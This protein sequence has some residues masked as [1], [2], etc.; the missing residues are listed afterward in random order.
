[1][2]KIGNL[3]VAAAAVS[4]AIVS[5]TVVNAAQ[6]QSAESP[7]DP[8]RIEVGW[9]KGTKWATGK[10]PKKPKDQS[11]STTTS[12]PTAGAPVPTTTAPAPTTSTSTP[13]ATTTTV[14]SI[15]T[16]PP[17]STT[18]STT[19]STSPIAQPT[20]SPA[21]PVETEAR[22]VDGSHPAASDANPGTSDLPWRTLT[23]AGAAA[24]AGDRVLIRPGTYTEGLDVGVSGAPGSRVVF[25]AETA[26][27][28]VLVNQCVSVKGRSH[29]EIRGL[30]IR[31]CTGGEHDHVGV[32][33][34]GPGVDDVVVADNHIVNTFSSAIS[35]WGVPWGQD[36]G[37]FRNIT[38][39][40]VTGNL[41]EQANNGGWNEQIT[42]AN[43]VVGFEIAYNELRDSHNTV[44]GGEGIDVKEGS[45]DGTIHHN[46]IHDIGRRAIYLDGGGRSYSVPPIDNVVVH[47]NIA[48]NVPNGF[49][50]MSEGGGDVTNIRVEN[51]LFYNI[52]ND[53]IFMYDHPNTSADPGIGLFRNITFVNNTLADCGREQTWRKGIDINTSKAT[54]VVIR[55]NIAWPRGID[56]GAAETVDHNLTSDPMFVNR[57]TGDFR[58][59]AGSAAVGSGSMSGAPHLDIVG[60]ARLADAAVDIGAYER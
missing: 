23:K 19:T 42:L 2:N 33:I 17:P 28:V 25:E 22:Y 53:C 38:N 29:I 40:V 13:T 55:N 21:P 32:S 57:A 20:T 35:A 36:P 15:V 14:V 12:A 51:N 8:D 45:S 26:G 27:T 39:L 54:G 16:T 34:V 6:N 11:S 9:S 58:V 49:A 24:E 56:S 1:M 52:G 41:I 60:T 43:G 31:D 37:A 50:I 44:N 59:A 47:S 3:T 10:P 48:Y 46:V 7:T 18:S 30:A 5:A 4:L